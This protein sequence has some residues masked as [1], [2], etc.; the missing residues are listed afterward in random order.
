MS[1][2]APSHPVAADERLA[3]WSLEAEQSV[4]GS[5]L[6][7]HSMLGLV[8]GIVSPAD[9]YRSQHAD[10]YAG[11]LALHGQHE[12]I[13][14][15]TLGDE[16]RRRGRLEAVG[17]PAYLAHLMNSVPTAVHAGAYARIVAT[18]A[19]SRRTIAAAGRIAAVG[20]EEATDP[21]QLLDRLQDI[22]GGIVRSWS[23]L[24]S[25]PLATATIVSAPEFLAEDERV[26]SEQ[27][28][29]GLLPPTG[30]AVIASP[31]KS[32]KT[33]LAFQVG[34]AVAA[35]SAGVLGRRIGRH[36]PVL[37]IE[38]EG[39][40]DR[41]RD[42]LR[43]QV[44][45]L[46]L[47]DA[48]AD[49]HFALFE[50]VR[51]D[52]PASWALIRA[53]VERLRPVLVVL[54]PFSYLHGQDE[55]ENWAMNAKVMRP[56]VSL[57]ADYDLLALVLHHVIKARGDGGRTAN[58]IRGAGGITAAT[59]ANIVMSRE[60]PSL[61]RFQGEYRDS[62][63]VDAFFTLESE[64]MILVEAD[65]PEK[66]RKVTRDQVVAYVGQMTKTTPNQAAKEWEVSR[67]TALNALLDA[68][69]VG[70]IDHF[71]DRGAHQFIAIEG[72]NDAN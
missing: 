24:R 55:N 1:A 38:E 57:A 49:L 22:V 33:V 47:E 46:E 18:R 29:E 28:I 11:A 58:R 31:P 51:I 70:L 23:A 19:L 45:A 54:D 44:T 26:G 50:K 68:A 72:V 7:D 16:L 14:L 35:R 8:E 40:R 32:A 3:P 13:D 20:Y 52:E 5:I 43:R 6:I 15:V 34:L 25:A 17:G 4:L 53:E 21:E 37:I 62:D 48:P 63:P 64:R 61:V 41:L 56:L 9:F 71:M 67:N 69:Q 27:L 30:V 36:G 12:P 60:G 2:K 42:R 59:D 65:P 66:G 39:G 10:I